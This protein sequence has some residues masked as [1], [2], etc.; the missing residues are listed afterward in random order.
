MGPYD[1][2]GYDQDA[3]AVGGMGDSEIIG[4]DNYDLIG[5]NPMWGVV[6][7]Q[8]ASQSQQLR[9][10]EVN[11]GNL[12]RLDP[13]AIAVRQRG[14]NRRRRFPIGFET[15]V[16]PAGATANIPAAPQNLF[17]MERL[18]VPSDIAF[19]CVIVD[20]KIGNTSQLV[21]GGEVPAA[22]FT[23][24]AIDTN[25]HF[26]TAE[27]GNQISIIIRNVSL[28]DLTFKAAA[29]GSVAL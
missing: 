17:R 15:T 5:E 4:E 11:M 3:Y 22:I 20:L 19:D 8:H 25:V 6:G 2:I 7:A 10:A 27:V 12:R 18:I 26:K 16:I 23:E 14:L 24:V 29:I 1:L 13:N 28:A 9:Q 21:S